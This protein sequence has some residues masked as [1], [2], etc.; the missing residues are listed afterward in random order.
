APPSSGI[1]SHRIR[2]T[3]M[4]GKAAEAMDTMTNRTRSNVGSQPRRRAMPPMTPAIIRSSRER[5]KGRE[6]V[7][8]S[9]WLGNA[10]G[11]ADHQRGRQGI[12]GPERGELPWAAGRGT[13]PQRVADVAGGGGPGEQ[14]GDRH[15][16]RD[17]RALEVRDLA[18]AARQLLGGD[19]VARQ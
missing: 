10:Q 17:R 12:D 4:P 16:G 7:M 2:Y 6:S 1:S 18:L 14:A 3:R 5:V 13:A 9:S 11:L 19:V 15:A 8:A